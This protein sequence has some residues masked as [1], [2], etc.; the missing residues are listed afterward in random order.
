MIHSLQFRLWA[1][2][3]LAILITIGSVFL[4]INQTAKGEI[5][6]F[7]ERSQ[8]MSDAR[9]NFVLGRHYQQTG[10]WT[11]VQP[12][13]EGA[14]GL[15]GRRIILTDTADAVVADSQ[16]EM[17]GM[18]YRPE[19]QGKPISV[20][21]QEAPMG[22]LYLSLNP[23]DRPDPFSPTP[24]SEAVGRFLLW[25]GLLAVAVAAL[26]TWLLSRRIL[27]PVKVLT[28]ST[29]RLGKGDL[30]E[31]VQ[32]KDKGELGELAEAFNSMAD[33]LERAEQLKRSMVADI[34]HELRTPL[35]NLRSYLEAVRDGVKKPD[36]ETIRTLDEESALLARLVDDLQELSLADAGEL[37][38][39]CRRENVVELVRRTVTGLQPTV[40]AK[41]LSLAVN[42]PDG[43][44]TVMVDAHRI[45]E[46]LRNLLE[47]AVAHTP[48][49]GSISVEAGEED[50]WVKVVITDTGEGIPHDDLPSIF[51]RFYRVD[52]SR[53]RATGGRGLGLTI[54][55]RLVEAHGGKID[56]S[57][58][59]G[60]GS[61]FSFTVPA[62][63]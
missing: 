40:A 32:V 54:T 61:R 45:S 5:R 47:N 11:D 42:L 37:K 60:K 30:S 1:A 4:F 15:F 24:V 10:S 59:L 38:L 63:E 34:A 26:F 57:S 9:M 27:A 7:W 18:H 44:P 43:L 48:S 55:K 22:T 13:V 39:V 14:G 33:S 16:G 62:A 56:A 36:E 8:Q 35:S 12:L 41:G 52:R 19:A 50:G 51:E 25:G 46:V 17:L 49:G 23:S 31:R 20:P 2:L 28:H 58:E 53:A 29:R 3:T 21:W 6:N